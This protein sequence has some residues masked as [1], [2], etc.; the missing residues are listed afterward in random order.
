VKLFNRVRVS[1]ATT[2]TGTITLGAAIT[3]YQTPASAGAVNGDVGSWAIEDGSAWELFVGTYASAGPTLTR[4]LIA[5]S[6][7][8]L[9]NLSGNAQVFST[10]LAHDIG[11]PVGQ[12]S[13]ALSGGNLVLSPKN[14]NNLSIN[15]RLWPIPSGGVSLAA[16]SLSAGTTYYIYA[17]MSGSTMTLEASTTTHATDAATGVEI[18]SGD[19]TRTLVGMARPVT[20]PAWVD[21]A[22]QRFV[23]SWFNRRS[24]SLFNKLAGQGSTGSTTF[25]EL[26]STKK[27]EFLV[28][29]EESVSLN[30]AGYVTPGAG[31]VSSAIGIDGTADLNS[32]SRVAGSAGI[33]PINTP[34]SAN[35]S[36]GYHYATQMAASSS[37]T[38]TFGIAT[39]T[40]VVHFNGLFGSIQ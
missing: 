36:E 7:G 5:S 4:T 15:G 34:Y 17:Y 38:A 8:S 27:V 39:E 22:A 20:G 25:A 6:T 32:A 19:A 13:L 9:L 3:G 11:P 10:A 18:K 30:T 28:W 29:S 24:L 26:D 12:A 2:G 23:R 35:L 1:T 31:N 37:G 16:T 14:G 21:S 33:T 40:A